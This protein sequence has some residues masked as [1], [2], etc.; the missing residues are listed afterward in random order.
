MHPGTT[1][2]RYPHLKFCYNRQRLN[3]YNGQLH[4]NPWI[5]LNHQKVNDKPHQTIH[6]AWIRKTGAG[7][8]EATIEDL[9]AKIA[10]VNN[11]TKRALDG[12]RSI[13]AELEPRR[14]YGYR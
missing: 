13:V 7:N 12:D 2:V 8:K 6:M 5:G 9:R 3:S 10:W 11:L 1:E 4:R 14:P